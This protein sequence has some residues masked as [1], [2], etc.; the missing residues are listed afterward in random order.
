M[1]L[2]NVIVVYQLRLADGSTIEVHPRNC[3]CHGC[4]LPVARSRE[5]RTPV[6]TA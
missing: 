2:Y 4:R 3:P 1:A 5:V 6:R